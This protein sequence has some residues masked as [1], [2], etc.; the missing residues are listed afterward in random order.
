MHHHEAVV[1]DHPGEGHDAEP[2]EEGQV[3]PHEDVPPDG[4]DQA[5]GNRHHDDRRLQVGFERY[6]QE[7]V[8]HQQSE[9]ES[10]KDPSHGFPLLL[11]L[12]L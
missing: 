4:P 8:D 3:Q 12:P 2:G 6:R 7:A 1:D 10:P 11:L 9:E 5:E